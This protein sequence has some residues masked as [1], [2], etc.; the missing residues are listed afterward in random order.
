MIFT[1]QNGLGNE[2]FLAEHFGAER[3]LGGLCFICLARIKPGVIELYDNGQ[4]ALGEFSGFPQPRLHDLAWEFKCYGI[5]C[6]VVAGLALEHRYKLVWNIPFNGLAVA[7]GGID[8]DKILSD[9]GL[10]PL[11]VELMD[12]TITIANRCGHNLPTAVALDQIKRT[13]TME[14]YKPSTLLDYLAGGP[15]EI[16]AVWGEP[17]RRGREAGPAILRLEMLYRLLVSLNRSRR[18]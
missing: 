10:R 1:L 12:E 17:L 6:S 11:A 13:E 8:I 4:L 16:E 7:A 2:Q 5:V 9:A 15:M 18:K 14:N 3:I